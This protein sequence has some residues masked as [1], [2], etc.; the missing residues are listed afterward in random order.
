MKELSKQV[1]IYWRL[2]KDV[3]STPP[4][5]IKEKEPVEAEVYMNIWQQAVGGEF[6]GA[7]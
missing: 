4:F 3:L 5:A 1:A 7:V 2:L 6:A